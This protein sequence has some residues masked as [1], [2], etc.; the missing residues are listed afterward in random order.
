M[1][2]GRYLFPVRSERPNTNGFY[3]GILFLFCPAVVGSD[4]DVVLLGDL[5]DSLLI[6]GICSL[7]VKTFVVCLDIPDRW[8]G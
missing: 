3:H 4:G 6:R 5:L 1:K 2:R 7:F 8:R